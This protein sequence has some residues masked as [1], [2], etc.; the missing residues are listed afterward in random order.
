MKEEFKISV[1]ICQWYML[2]HRERRKET[3]KLPNW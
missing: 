3:S 1:I 2:T